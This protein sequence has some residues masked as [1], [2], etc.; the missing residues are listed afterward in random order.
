MSS[1]AG[2]NE[3]LNIH[4]REYN[5][6]IRR[7]WAPSQPTER[8]WSHT[9]TVTHRSCCP[10]SQVPLRQERPSCLADNG[11][12]GAL[13]GAGG[14]ERRRGVRT[15]VI[16]RSAHVRAYVPT[17]CHFEERRARP[18]P[19]G[20]WQI[21]PAWRGWAEWKKTTAVVVWETPKSPPVGITPTPRAMGRQS[22]RRALV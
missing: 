5:P 12:G 18:R 15:A 10:G 20:T 19:R 2:T 13:A 16:C 7:S 6:Q 9:A 22:R 14:K 3:H 4:G 11:M 8:S 17:E 21:A 1:Q